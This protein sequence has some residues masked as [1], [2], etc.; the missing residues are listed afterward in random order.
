MPMKYREVLALL[1]RG[2]WVKARQKGS[3][4]QFIHPT[5][6]GTITVAGKDNQEVPPGTLN[7]I[8]KQAG[9]K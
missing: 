2:G 7:V 4:V 8:L 3:H 5:K 6:P 9:L 1:R